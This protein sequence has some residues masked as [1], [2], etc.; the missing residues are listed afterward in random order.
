MADDFDE[1]TM[2]LLRKAFA[3]ADK[4]KAGS[5]DVT[6]LFGSL[7]SAGL[8]P[9]QGDLD[10]AVGRLELTDGK[11]TFSNFVLIAASFMEED[12]EETITNELREAFR[13]YDRDDKGF[14]TTKVLREILKELDNKI[15]EKDMDEIID[16]IDEDGKGKIDFAHFKALMI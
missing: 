7:F 2:Q 15:T 9:D 16:D 8:S 11:V 4:S 13:M 6:A 5:I 10:E 12:D 14:I 1:Q 3:V